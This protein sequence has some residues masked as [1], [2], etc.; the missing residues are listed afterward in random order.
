M[1]ISAQ[2]LHQL[3]ERINAPISRDRQSDG[4]IGLKNVH[5]RI[6]L[7]YGAEYGVRVF[8]RLGEYTSVV[9][10]MGKEEKKF[11]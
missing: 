9:L 4:N 11:V 2:R 8:S 5:R 1:G 7:S 3:T 10:E 6:Q